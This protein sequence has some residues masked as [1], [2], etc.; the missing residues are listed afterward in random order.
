MISI[1]ANH[2]GDVRRVMTASPFLGLPGINWKIPI[3]KKSAFLTAPAP[4]LGTLEHQN[5][6]RG[7]L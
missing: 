3:M 1:T 6:S 5:L 2:R 7:R 4:A